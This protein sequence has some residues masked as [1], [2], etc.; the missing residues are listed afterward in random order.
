V[1]ILQLKFGIIALLALVC[2]CR[3]IQPEAPVNENLAE[4]PP[5]VNS[6]TN[7]IVVPVE[8]N[9]SG[10]F[11]QA[12]KTV[13]EITSGSDRPCS[14]IRYEFQFQKD[15]FGISTVNNQLLAE[16]VGSYW[17]KMEY[18]AG[19]TD[20]F[21]AKPVCVSPL[22]PFSCGI[23]EPMPSLKI[24]F[25]TDLHINENYALESKT[26]VQE[27]KPLNPCEVTFFRFDATG[28]V[29]KEVRKT[30]K[31]QCEETDKQL[32]SITFKNEAAEL[33]KNMNQTMLVPYLGYIHFEPLSLSLV[34]P[35]LAN[36][37]L[38]TTLVLNCKTYLNQNATKTMLPELPK[39]SI[40]SR[41]PKDT[42][43]LLTDFELNY[44]SISQLFT[45]QVKG[46][47]VQ[48]KKNHF[49]FESVKVSGLDQKRISLAIQFKGTKKGTLYLA[50]TPVFDNENG[51]LKLD[52][53]TYD[54]KTKSLL[55]KSAK[56]LFSDRIYT[57]LQKATQIDFAK[58][59]DELKKSIDQNLQQKNGDFYISGKTHDINVI[60]IFPT[61]E[62][63]YL[64]TCL[65]AQLN[66]K[67]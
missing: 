29:I 46:K 22:V 56:W 31:K 21:S 13:P 16:L 63:L 18:C 32:S 48:I 9:L 25:A 65:K 53:L 4:T 15:S 41:A 36:N 2:S 17:I 52:N 64:R 39:L 37:K 5:P 55:I 7:N 59:L 35:R 40:I 62:K 19:C 38:Y 10:Y 60:H 44:D 45:T 33:W 20:M 24:R 1:R 3:S 8:I 42:F 51:I 11:K 14:G 49:E 66:V 27:L 54:L 12:N 50:G 23:G 43:E 58:D 47:S 28:E 57:E 34:K 67:Q 26:S 61:I 6:L 30:L